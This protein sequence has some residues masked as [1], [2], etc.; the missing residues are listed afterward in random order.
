[1]EKPRYLMND[2]LKMTPSDLKSLETR[3]WDDY[4]RVKK[5]REVIDLAQQ[6]AELMFDEGQVQLALKET[7]KEEE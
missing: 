1:M 2:L 7:E 3:L 5:A 6:D 4:L